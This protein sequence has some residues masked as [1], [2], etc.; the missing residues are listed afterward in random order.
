MNRFVR[1]LVL[2][3]TAIGFSGCSENVAPKPTT[4]FRENIPTDQAPQPGA[5]KGKP[6]LKNRQVRGFGVPTNES[7]PGE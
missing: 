5:K 4:S 3:G 1:G 2:S 7:K 6:V